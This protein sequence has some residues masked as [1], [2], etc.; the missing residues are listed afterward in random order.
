MTAATFR[1]P[2]CAG[3]RQVRDCSEFQ[4]LLYHEWPV[5]R[6]GGSVGGVNGKTSAQNQDKW[7]LEDG[8]VGAQLVREKRVGN[9]SSE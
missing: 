9:E 8:S 5:Q 7:N 3:L 4:V 6:R 1:T 2:S